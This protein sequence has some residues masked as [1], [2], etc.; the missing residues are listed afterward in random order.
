MC[1][2]PQEGST[3]Y[4]RD[5]IS[6]LP[7]LVRMHWYH[8]FKELSFDQA[9]EEVKTFSKDFNSLLGAS[10]SCSDWVK[11]NIYIKTVK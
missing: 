11:D 7:E 10:R 2:H 3:A 6:V 1:Q 8:I 9:I 5:A 4:Q